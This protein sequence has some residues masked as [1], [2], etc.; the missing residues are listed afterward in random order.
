M[1]TDTLLTLEDAGKQLHLT[2]SQMFELTRTRSRIRQA[3]PLPL[4]RLG[5]RKYIRQ[6]SLNKWIIANEQSEVVQ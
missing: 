3:V 5:K 4:V 1:E 2:K 6:S